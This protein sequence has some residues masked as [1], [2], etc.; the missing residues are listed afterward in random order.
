[1]ENTRVFVKMRIEQ[2][3][4]AKNSCSSTR[5]VDFETD[6]SPLNQQS[7]GVMPMRLEE[8]VDGEQVIRMWSGVGM[9]QLAG[10]TAKEEAEAMNNKCL[11]RLN[12]FTKLYLQE[13]TRDQESVDAAYTLALADEVGVQKCA[14]AVGRTDNATPAIASVRHFGELV[15]ESVD[16]WLGPDKLAAM[17]PEEQKASK[18]IW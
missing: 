12:A 18:K 3:K 14:G 8:M 7:F 6:E 9:Y 2:P 16:T 5:V 13:L 10:Q 15:G 17:S 1:M 4:N 11:G